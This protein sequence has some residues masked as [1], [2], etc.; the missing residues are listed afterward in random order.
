MRF[1]QIKK[2][3]VTRDTF[4]PL[5][6]GLGAGSKRRALQ[7]EN[8][9]KRE[10]FAVSF[11]GGAILPHVESQAVYLGT[12]WSA[13]ASLM[14]QRQQVDKYID[15]LV[16]SPYMDM[17]TN[18][19]YGVGRGISSPG[20]TIV[21]N[22][23]SLTDSQIQSSLQ[24]AISSSKLQQPDANRLY[25]VYVEPGISV[26][27][28]NSSS[29]NSFLGYHG[30]F[31]GRDA[32]GK[33]S[34]IRYAVIAYPGTPNPSA[35]SQG[36][37]KAFD[38][39]T[40]VT[41][42]ELAEAVTDPD[43]DYRKTGWYDDRNNGEIGDLTRQNTT[44]NGYLVQA[45]VDKNDRVIFPTTTS[46]PTQPVTPTPQ[47]TTPPRTVLAAP[48]N[49]IATATSSTKLHLSWDAAA[50][51]SGY[52]I[53]LVENGGAVSLIGAISASK[54]SADV[55]GL[56][57]GTTVQLYVQAFS[58]NTMA[59]S[60]SVSVNLPTVSATLKT[61]AVT[62]S[63]AANLDIQLTWDRVDGAEGYRVYHV[64]NN[65][66]QYL[67]MVS[68]DATGVN[69]RGVASGVT[70]QWIVQAYA[71]DQTSNSTPVSVTTQ[72]RISFQDYLWNVF[73]G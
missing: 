31:A 54:L 47:T 36:Y 30:A 73:F 71:G 4:R 52:R 25:I 40:S 6:N 21:Q 28:G 23:S 65:R 20:Q 39:L 35:G 37:S 63:V 32:S 3:F 53:F 57:A 45:V 41:S 22:G 18:A 17:L 26:Q 38:Q 11:H 42:H 5:P 12:D 19:G 27:M 49:V 46:T 51:A 8:L 66:M 15:Y 24:S 34:D 2:Y 67:G 7:C 13:N 14:D 1:L 44:L 72:R 60:A 68:A 48:Q 10:M 16:K 56:I 29:T 58:G 9:E 43:A 64:V 33:A 55:S 50:G 59:N 70:S 62:V 69:I 61:P